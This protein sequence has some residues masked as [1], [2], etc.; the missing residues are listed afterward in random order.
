[1]G[2]DTAEASLQSLRPRGLLVFFGQSSGA[3]PPIAPLRLNVLGSLF[4][5]RP[6]L[7]NYTATREELEMRADDVLGAVVDGSLRV[8]IGARYELDRAA[9]AQSALEGRATTGKV[10]LI[11]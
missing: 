3:V 9:E 11:P 7:A 5:T 8:R 4:I 6:S 10:L 1:V 2:K